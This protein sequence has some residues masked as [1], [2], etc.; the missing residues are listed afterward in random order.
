MKNV[1]TFTDVQ[2]KIY[3]IKKLPEQKYLNV[4]G[5]NVQA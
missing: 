4:Q 3:L 5:P 1:Q 2:G